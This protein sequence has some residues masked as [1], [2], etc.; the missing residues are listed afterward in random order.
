MGLASLETTDELEN[1]YRKYTTKLTAVLHEPPAY[2]TEPLTYR[3]TFADGAQAIIGL[4]YAPY[5]L[6]TINDTHPSSAADKASC[7]LTVTWTAPT[8]PL[9]T[10]P[11][12]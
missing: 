6:A 5:P 3:A 9:L 10:I 11:K 4:N 12:K 1:G 2:A 7:T 8:P